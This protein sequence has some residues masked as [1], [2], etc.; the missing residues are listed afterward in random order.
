MARSGREVRRQ[1]DIEQ[2]LDR[3]ERIGR[4]YLSMLLVGAIAL[5]LVP[6]IYLDES[7]RLFVLKLVR[8]GLLA[9]LPGWLYLQF[10]RNKGRSLYDEY[11]LNLFRLHIDKPAN[12][13]APPKHT[14]YYI[15][16]SK[17]HEKLQTRSKDNL[18]RTKFEAVYGQSS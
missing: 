1:V 12:L 13:P 2:A 15:P 7:S 14:T 16:W 17:A 4:L 3:A 6:T 8:A 10:I 5:I 9:F 11:V 18:Y